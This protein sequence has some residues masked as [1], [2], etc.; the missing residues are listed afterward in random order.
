MS[1]LMP[2]LST[3]SRIKP[4][5]P[6]DRPAIVEHSRRQ[7]GSADMLHTEGGQDAQLGIGRVMLMARKR[8][9]PGAAA[10]WGPWACKGLTP[11]PVSA[12]VVAAVLFRK[13]LRSMDVSLCN[14]RVEAPHCKRWRSRCRQQELYESGHDFTCGRRKTYKSGPEAACHGKVSVWG[15]RKKERALRQ[16]S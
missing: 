15:K 11:L 4:A 2:N 9:W 1:S 3:R 16:S 14:G 10:A 8:S 12:A 6:L 13:L 7:R 5:K